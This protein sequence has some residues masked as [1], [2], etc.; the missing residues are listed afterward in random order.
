MKEKIK[1]YILII[2]F[3]FLL[4]V[5]LSCWNVTCGIAFLC[6]TFFVIFLHIAKRLKFKIISTL[7]NQIKSTNW[8]KN[9][10]IYTNQFISN[11]GYRNNHQRNFKVVNVGS[12]PARFAFFYEDILGENWS[13]GTHLLD[14]DLDILKC[15]HSYLCEGATVIIPI[16]AFSSVSG[17]LNKRGKSVD[18]YA[19]FVKIL[20]GLQKKDKQWHITANDYINN[21]FHYNRNAWR[22]IFNDVK[23]DSRLD[24]SCNPLQLTEMIEDAKFWM[25]VW[26][27]EFNIKSFTAPLTEE[28][29]EG[30]EIAKEILCE[31]IGFLK[32]RGY[33]PVIV[34][35]PMS[36]ALM[37]HFTTKVKYNY[38]DSFIKEIQSIHEVEYFDY[39]GNQEFQKHEYYFNA[40]FMNLKGRKVFTKQLLKDLSLT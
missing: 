31:T 6:I 32:D 15:Y 23:N 17:L 16:V 29:I 30:R 22:Y 36:S 9:Q 24:I 12:N 21:P 10:F 38:I 35:P 14:A 4:G 11:D 26:K 2:A 28:L 13:T 25:N 18:Y 8:W 39:T 34:S 5:L 7:N 20:D 1:R 33:R 3:I 40:L 19:K 27:E 37:Q